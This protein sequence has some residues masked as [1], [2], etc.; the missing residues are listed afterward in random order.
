[1]NLESW[2][3]QEDDNE[4]LLPLC[5]TTKW[6]NFEKII[7]DKKLSASFSKFPDP[8]P[9]NQQ[10]E[11]L[12]YLFYGLPF[13]IYETGEDDEINSEVTEDL[14][15]GL[16][17]KQNLA[18]YT[19]RFYPFDTGALLSNKYKNILDIDNDLQ[20]Y[21]VNISNGTEMKKLVKRYYKTNEKYCYG[22]FNN[23]VNP[24]HPKEE[25]LIRLFLDG[26][27]SKVDLRNRA[28]EVHSLQDIDI[29]NNI[30]AVILPRLRSSKY[31]YIKTNLNLLSDDVDIVYY[32]D[33][34]R[35]NSE[36]IRNAVIEATM[37]YYD[38]NH[39]NMFSYSRL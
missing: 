29:S 14:P 17:F 10:V 11:N 3:S 34:T 39:S 23:T 18:S 25:N 38:K 36:S 37:N 28:I 35:F 19:D 5:H 13:Y 4:E 27:K 15:I 12:V 21:E 31:D 33:L 24:N 1:M 2:I 16:V 7:G 6:K 30:L 8:N 26:S 22:D 32:N 20:V 9:T